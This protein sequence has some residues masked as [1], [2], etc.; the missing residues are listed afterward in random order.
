MPLA[1]HCSSS[2]QRAIKTMKR[3]A[4]S[5]NIVYYDCVRAR[6][7][8]RVCVCACACA[9]VCVCTCFVCSDML[10]FCGVFLVFCVFLGTYGSPPSPGEG[11]LPS[12]TQ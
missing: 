12:K 10:F 6:L 5:P 11:G 1:V 7:C 8:V 3:L 9:C 4:H 2:H